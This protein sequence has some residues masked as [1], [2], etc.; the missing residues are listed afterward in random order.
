QDPAKLLEK[1]G[2][3][4]ELMHLKDIRKGA[5]VGVFT[6]RAPLT[7]DV[8]LG[9]GQVNWPE[10]L[11]AAAKAGVKHYF[12]EDE[13]PTVLDAIPVSLKYLQSL[14]CA[15]QP[16]SNTDLATISIST[17]SSSSTAHPRSANAGP[18]MT[19]N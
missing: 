18:S 14:N 16:G 10:V 3:R 4:W 8:P 12:I 2:K 6:G 7:D 17:R 19:V 15:P 1:Y 9:T 5:T 13:S 11:R